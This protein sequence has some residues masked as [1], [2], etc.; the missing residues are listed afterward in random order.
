MQGQKSAIGSLPETLNFDHGSTSSGAGL[1]Q[2]ICW[3]NMR[4]PAENRLADYIQP[5]SDTNLAFLNSISHGGQNLSGWSLGEPSSINTHNIASR[6]ERKAEHGWATSVSA[7]VGAGPRLEERQCEPSNVFS[8]DNVNVNPSS[9]QIANGPLFLQS[10]SSDAIAQNLN[11]NAGFVGSGGDGCQG[12]EC[13]NLYKSSGSENLPSAGSSSDPFGPRFSSGG[14]LMEEDDGRPGS[15]LEG[16]RLSCKR[17][18]LEGN[19]GQSSVGGSSSSFQRTESNAWHAVVPARYSVGN[20]LS[21][22]GPS[23][24]IIGDSPAEQVNPRLGLGARGVAADSLPVLNVPGS[25]ESSHRNFRMRINPSHQQDSA[26][27]N[28]FLTGGSVRHPNVSSNQQSS[29]LVPVNHA[30]D[31]R[32]APAADNAISQS[33][34]VANHTPNMPRNM[35]SFRWSRA[36]SRHGTSSNPLVSGERDAAPREEASSRSMPRH[37]LEHSM[38]LPAIDLRSLPQNPINRNLAVGNMTTPGNSASTSRTGSGSGVNSSSAST[39]VPPRDP[40]SQYSR[41]L[42]EYVRRS[43]FSSVGTEPGAQSSNYSPLHSGPSPSSQEVVPLSGAGNQ[44]HHQSYPRSALLME[45]HG[46]GVLGIPYSLRTLAAA[47]EGR[48]RLVSEVLS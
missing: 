38:F 3:N 27:H 46:D 5:P 36:S 16:R 18:A 20:S 32:S 17:K 13:P 40:P 8:L 15:S 2:Q 10:S 29:R 37:T 7:C 21:I 23:G 22:S 4:N 33:Q 26:P 28:L 24:N 1:D 35:Q 30:P 31:L 9:N 41:R 48:S 39:W 47:S 45:R 11:L 44:G 6:D 14:Y 19:I 43:L 25:A 12:L 42:S 34:S